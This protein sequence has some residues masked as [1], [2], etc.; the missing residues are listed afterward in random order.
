MINQDK[1]NALPADLQAIVRTAFQAATLDG[2][3]DFTYNSGVSLRKLVEE[4]GVK[5]RRYPDDVL[6]HLSDISAE[7][8]LEMS[9]ETE[10]M[11]RIYESYIAYRELVFPWTDISDR[12]IVNLRNS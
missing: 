5:L 9:Q 11:G 4:H 10:L 2:L 12:A 8:V 3:S 7:V 6:K 1:W